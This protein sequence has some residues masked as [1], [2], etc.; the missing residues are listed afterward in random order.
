MTSAARPSAHHPNVPS[1]ATALRAYRLQAG[2]SQEELADRSGLSVD[3]IS[4]L[5]RGVR[6]RAQPR[7]LRALGEALTLSVEDRT[8]LLY[9]AREADARQITA[10]A[11]T[12]QQRSLPLPAAA[13]R[14][15]GR[16]Q[17]QRRALEL[18]QRPEARLL[19]LTGPGG[20]GKTR[21]ALA[22]AEAAS[23]LA[24]SVC[25]VDL[26]TITD[27]SLLPAAMAQALGLREQGNREALAQVVD[28]ANDQSLL[29]VLDNFE[30]VQVAA[31]EVSR[32]LSRCPD[33]R[34]L[35]TSR[36]PL[37]IQ[38]EH[39][40][41]IFPLAV[42]PDDDGAYALHELLEYPS[43]RLFV[44]RAQAVDPGFRLTEENGGAVAAICR[45]LDGLPLALELAAARTRILPLPALLFRLTSRFALLTDGPVDAPAR[46]RTLRAAIAWSHDLLDDAERAAFRRLSVFAGGFSFDAAGAVLA[47][48]A[49]V[50]TDGG[51]A[52]LH[53]LDALLSQNLIRRED[54]EGTAGH[55]RYSMLETV[56]EF[57]RERLAASG[58]TSAAR[59]AHA[60]WHQQLVTQSAAELIGPLQREWLIR[61]DLEYAN[62]RLALDW[63]ELD[64]D[65]A[66]ALAMA[67]GLAW[68][69]WYRGLYAEG[70]ARLDALVTR[71]SARTAPCA[72]AAAMDGL[73]LLVRA[74]GD[75]AQAVTIHEQALAV[76]R[77]LGSRDQLADGL[78][79]YGLALMYAG[80]QLARQVLVECLQLARTLPQPHWLGGTLWALGRTLRYRGE[81]AAAR[82]SLE[83][84]LQRAEAIGNPSGIAVSLWGLGEVQ[85][86]QGETDTA[87]ATLQEALRRLWD[88]GEIWSAILCL[89]R[90]VRLLA[91]RKQAQALTIAA[92]AA[93]WR[94]RVGLPL[95]PVD[96]MPLGWELARL[97]SLL[98]PGMAVALEQRGTALSPAEVVA[99]ALAA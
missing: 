55:T 43:I 85:L 45:R 14:L 89:E 36:S 34:L 13:T 95:P 69:W 42:P 33:L 17:E 77:E 12:R 25:F 29:L 32:L 59:A 83:E 11:Q 30:H 7:T 74:R 60:R 79:L 96:A 92:A 61:L 84:A 52:T 10:T 22:V 47:A 66:P 68:Y 87:L 94:S 62:L 53:L 81:L 21:V 50:E 93:A 31:P 37:R 88:L 41:P 76:W 65:A 39:E 78:F 23:A 5:E 16:S 56:R 63:L 73:G 44:E 28:L 18:L 19:T 2:L 86:D 90:I 24:E 97:R 46:H 82:E 27:P 49:P 75:I 71:P 15:I 35:V 80:D 48:F 40:L 38:G 72:W 98:D 58:E 91:R 9:L 26:T 99:L 67:A 4:A 70:R 6:R 1:L 20:V 8:H 51:D 54:T 57:G 3:A 64:E